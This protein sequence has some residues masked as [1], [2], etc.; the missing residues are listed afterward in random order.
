MDKSMI[1]FSL[2]YFLVEVSTIPQF[3]S[4]IF[5]HYKWRKCILQYQWITLQKG[6]VTHLN[7]WQFPRICVFLFQRMTIHNHFLLSH[8]IQLVLPFPVQW[9]SFYLFAK[10][11]YFFQSRL[12]WK[13][14]T[15]IIMTVC[16]CHVTY[17]F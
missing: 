15:P 5:L 16:S 1:L 7:M 17:A 4:F 13:Y 3:D 2:V 11:F 14:E 9:Y 10:S 8:E 12:Q 6:L